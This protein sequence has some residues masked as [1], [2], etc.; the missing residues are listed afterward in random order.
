MSHCCTF[1]KREK[2]YNLSKAFLQIPFTG[3]HIQFVIIT[4][5]F[6]TNHFK[7]QS[8]QTFLWDVWHTSVK[9]LFWIIFWKSS[10]TLRNSYYLQINTN[11]DVSLLQSIASSSSSQASSDTAK[12]V[13]RPFKTLLRIRIW[14]FSWETYLVRKQLF[15]GVLKKSCSENMQQIY[16]GTPM[17]KCDFNKVA[18]QL[19]WNCTSA[20]VFSC[21]FAAFFQNTF[22]KN[23]SEWL[24][25]LV[26]M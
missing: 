5:Q 26:T 4:K 13:C 7:I 25:L 14:W 12:T 21:K 15:R 8:M 10:F 2:T 17:A 16:G 19:Y 18:L 20:W 11:I 6:P 1:W 9:Y 23:T 3:L 22:Y 24:L